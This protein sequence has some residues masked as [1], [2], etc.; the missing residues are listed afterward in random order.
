MSVL[1]SGGARNRRPSPPRWARDLS[2]LAAGAQGLFFFYQIV[3]LVTGG[4]IG[5]AL[6]IDAGLAGAVMLGFASAAHRLR[7][8]MDADA[9]GS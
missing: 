2:L 5:L 3:D 6:W 4:E 9:R 8:R 7:L 1:N